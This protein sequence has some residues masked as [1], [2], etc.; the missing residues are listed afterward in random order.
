MRNHKNIWTVESS[1]LW[2]V[3]LNSFWSFKYQ[4]LE[5]SRVET[6][7][8]KSP[9]VAKCKM[10]KYL[11]IILMIATSRVEMPRNRNLRHEKSKNA[12]IGNCERR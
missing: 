10:L 8:H 12:E 7:H 4:E 1:R 3:D 9:E 6:L 2:T 5:E 11:Q